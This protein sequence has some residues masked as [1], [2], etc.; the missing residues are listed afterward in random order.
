MRSRLV[1]D[2]TSAAVERALDLGL[3]GLGGALSRAPLDAAEALDLTASEHD[4][5]TARRVERFMAV[6]AGAVV[7]TR[8][9]QGLFHRGTVAGPWHYDAS[10]AAAAVDLVHVRA[11]A[12]DAAPADPPPAVLAT[13]ARGG[14]NFQRIRAL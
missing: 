13:Y 6:A 11:C 5:R 9:A 3:V 4:E 7:W 2:T 1:P 12:W 8:D 14:L 10:A